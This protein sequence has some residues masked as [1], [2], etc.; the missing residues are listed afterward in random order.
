MHIQ[1]TIISYAN[2]TKNSLACTYNNTMQLCQRVIQ[3][4]PH[5][6]NTRITHSSMHAFQVTKAVAFFIGSKRLLINFTEVDYSRK[7]KQLKLMLEYIVCLHCVLKTILKDYSYIL[8]FVF[9]CINVQLNSLS[10]DMLTFKICM[11]LFNKKYD[12]FVASRSQYT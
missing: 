3:Q 2:T 9:D 10:I 12:Y 11:H 5:T 4:Q 7:H 1:P 8:S 6:K